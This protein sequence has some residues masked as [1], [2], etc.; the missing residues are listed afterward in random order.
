MNVEQASRQIDTTTLR[1]IFYY[2]ICINGLQINT[3]SRE[4]LAKCKEA[5]ETQ[6]THSLSVT[7]NWEHVDR[8]LV[9]KDWD[10]L[11][12]QL[13]KHVTTTAVD[14]VKMQL[15]M[16]EHFE[17][18]CRFYTPS[19]EAYVGM[20]IFYKENEDMWKFHY[21]YHPEMVDYLG[22]AIYHYADSNL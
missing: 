7:N 21:S 12:K 5:L 19:K 20:G 16:K 3:L 10:T 4:Y 8:N 18:A 14:N 15:L 6:Q 22:D 1:V 11:Y 2:K 9:H 17:I 13:S